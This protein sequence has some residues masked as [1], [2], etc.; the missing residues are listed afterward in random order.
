MRRGETLGRS[1]SRRSGIT[2]LAG[3]L[4]LAILTLTVVIAVPI[5][6]GYKDDAAEFTC[7]L[8]LDKAQDYLDFEALTDRTMTE[9]EAEL[10]VEGLGREGLCPDGGEFFVVRDADREQ[11]LTVVCGLHDTD[12]KRRT[13]LCADRVLSR[14]RDAVIHERLLGREYP[15][16]LTILLNSREL[17]VEL[18]AE[19][20]DLKWGTFATPGYSG[21]AAFYSLAGY[22][23][24]GDAALSDGTVNYLSFADENHCANWLYGSGWS[25]DSYT[26]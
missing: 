9:E 17:A 8:A 15:A 12:T 13:R 26:D 7:T 20:T 16:K 25:G 5:L 11:P 18:V 21:T 4:I 24:L 23:T 6:R 2:V 19:E 14:V 3:I 22:S 1:A 10:A